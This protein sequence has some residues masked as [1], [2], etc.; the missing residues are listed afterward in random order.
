MRNVK[1]A[2]LTIRIVK[3][4]ES[5]TIESSFMLQ[6]P[7]SNRIGKCVDCVLV[8]RPVGHLTLLRTILSYFALD[9]SSFLS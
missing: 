8:I 4:G 1:V 6:T 7:R 3:K 9:V 2:E 5:Y